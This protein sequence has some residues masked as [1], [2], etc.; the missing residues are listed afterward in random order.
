MKKPHFFSE[1][2][3]R[4]KIFL[5]NFFVFAISLICF[6][7][8][9]LSLNEKQVRLLELRQSQHDS[10]LVENSIDSIIKQTEN[11]LKVLSN[12]SNLQDVLERKRLGVESEKLLELSI[13]QTIGRSVSNIISPN[14]EIIG[15]IVWV[16]DDIVYSGYC[17][18]TEECYNSFDTDYLKKIEMEKSP[19]WDD[20]KEIKFSYGEFANVFPVS[21]M[22]INKELGFPL[23]KL[24]LLL[25]EQNIASIYSRDYEKTKKQFFIMDENNI[26][27][28]S[29]D[30]LNIGKN[31]YQLFGL[32]EKYINKLN[33]DDFLFN[34]NYLYCQNEY[35]HL[36]WKIISVYDISE[37]KNNRRIQLLLFILL[38]LILL[39]VVLI[40]SY[41]ISFSVTKPLY[42]IS[43]GMHKIGQGELDLRIPVPYGDRDLKN[44]AI[45]FNNLIDK[46]QIL[47]DK[48]YYQQKKL[49]KSELLLLQA[50][51]K[52]HFLYNTMETISSLIKLGL[53][54]KALDALQFLSNF[55]RKSLSNGKNIVSI[56][57]EVEIIESYLQIQS[58]RYG[59]LM[60]WFI[61]IEEEIKHFLIPKLILQ[62]LIE[63]AIYHGIKQNP[64]PGE[65]IVCGYEKNEKIFIEVFDTGI[66]MKKNELKKL[67]N[68]ILIG[69]E[70]SNKKTF[71]L[72]NV[73]E[74]LKMFF[75][76][77]AQLNVKSVEGEYFQVVIEIVKV[78]EVDE[79]SNS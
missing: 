72:H 6:S 58:L 68:K 19:I 16:G 47:I 49:R 37:F 28:S 40:G 2:T 36:G 39:V 34:K 18:E 63:N 61:E 14:T 21:K 48:I 56:G 33:N 54:D 9:V 53:E 25:D 24:T 65:I 27:V 73:S 3:L 41:Y 5:F 66:G 77:D 20:E 57:E 75:K 64:K 30:K 38:I 50:Q 32:K 1:L 59:N 74:R 51:I 46:L 23:G 29:S 43:E 42:Q 4:S 69:E 31:G 45:D 79:T 70:T 13:S 76:G 55:Y 52:P 22:I 17:L 7:T 10:D 26:I 62:P 11:L 8:I 12:E 71:G 78:E 35:D 67:Q 15:A 44:F 60:Q